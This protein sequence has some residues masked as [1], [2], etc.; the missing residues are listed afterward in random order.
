MQVGEI[1]KFYRER[2][3]LTQAQLGE[4]ICTATHVSKIEHGKTAF[5][6]EIIALF[7]ERLQIDIQKEIES[8]QDIE[9]QL[10]HWHNAII[11]QRMK[12]VEMIKE[13]LESFPFIHFSKYASLYLLL[14]IRYYLLKDEGKKAYQ[15]IQQV[16]KRHPDLPPF[17]RN[18]LCHIKGIYYL[19]HQSHSENP[20]KAIQV[21]K[22]INIEEYGNPEYYYHLAAGYHFAE[23]KIMSYHYAEKA[24]RHFKKTNNYIHSFNAE[25]LILLQVGSDI[26]LDFTELEERYRNLISDSEILGAVNKTGMFHSNLGYEY[27]RRKEF[28]K[29]QKCYEE[30]LRLAEKSSKL[31]LKRLYNYVN[32]CLEGKLLRKSILLKK[33]REG[34]ALARQFDSQLYKIL[35][36]LLILAIEDQIDQYYSYLEKKALPYFKLNEYYHWINIFGKKLFTHYAET[37]QPLK[38]FQLSNTLMNIV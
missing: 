28:A 35:F 27:Y 24:L 15:M 4:G 6:S 9:K 12:D 29:A 32:T 19:F 34:I 23:S 14:Q 33:A 25:A 3:G 11:M 16:K 38:A 30:A 26:Y 22:Q 5:S 20:H 2:N 37:E 36:K 13:R 18:L 31:Y 10:H 8:F 7:S 21:L 1:I 17:E